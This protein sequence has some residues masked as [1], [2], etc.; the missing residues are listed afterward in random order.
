MKNMLLIAVGLM[1]SVIV[2]CS[3]VKSV[4]TTTGS[5]SEAVYE[6][7]INGCEALPALSKQ[8]LVGLIKTKLDHYPE[9]GICD[10]NWVRNVL[11]KKLDELEKN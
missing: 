11:L 4:S 10:R 2:G 1:L 5:F 8:L 3:T 7:K 9:N 6:L